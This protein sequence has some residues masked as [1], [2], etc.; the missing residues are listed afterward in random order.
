MF[1]LK[2]ISSSLA[3]ILSFWFGNVLA[4]PEGWKS[5]PMKEPSRYKKAHNL[6]NEMTLFKRA[7]SDSYAFFGSILQNPEETY[8]A[9]DILDR[10]LGALIP[11][12]EFSKVQKNEADRYEISCDAVVNE[13]SVRFM[14]VYKDLTYEGLFLVTENVD[15]KDLRELGFDPN[16]SR[17][18]SI[19]STKSKNTN[20]Q[21]YQQ[22]R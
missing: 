17:E 20:K 8:E 4:V 16:V 5:D 6:F 10:F 15:S 19:T 18:R 1:N 9:R 7:S 12:Y 13:K 11:C 14:G 3:V 22:G 2:K 21:G